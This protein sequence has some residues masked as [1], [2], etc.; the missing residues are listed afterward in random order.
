[1]P[2]ILVSRKG[3]KATGTNNA[4]QEEGAKDV[5]E[6]KLNNGRNGRQK[7]VGGSQKKEGS[8][9]VIEPQHTAK[10]KSEEPENKKQTL[11]RSSGESFYYIF[12]VYNR[13]VFGVLFFP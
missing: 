7:T 10:H 3:T 11:R 9:R 13:A 4:L 2:H 1:L 8:P 12:Y 6:A 5:N